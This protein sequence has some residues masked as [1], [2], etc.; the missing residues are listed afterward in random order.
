V[1]N[2]ELCWE[3]NNFKSCLPLALFPVGD[4]FVYEKPPDVCYPMLWGACYKS[5]STEQIFIRIYKHL[6]IH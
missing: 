4:G 6:T 2:K 1:V 5:S 3:M